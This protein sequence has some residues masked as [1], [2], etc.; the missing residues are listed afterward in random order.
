MFMRIIGISGALLLAFIILGISI[1][2]IS[3]PNYAFYQ[4][5]QPSNNTAF[6][7]DVDYYFPSPGILP[8]N[9]FWGIKVLRDKIWLAVTFDH[10]KRAR[11]ELLFADKRVV[12]GEQ[13]MQKGKSSL[14]TS[15]TQK[16]EQYLLDTYREVTQEDQAK[17]DT[18][19]LYTTLAKSSLRHRET[20]EYE[21]SIAPEDAQPILSKVLDGPKMVYQE[22]AQKLIQKGK[23]VPQAKEVS[24]QINK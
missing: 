13:L 16:A 12:M 8:D 11:L 17:P 4:P 15:T 19:D 22:C 10:I 21:I 2:R 1:I 24:P 23:V 14:A 20:I 5:L 7:T 3:A 6:I 9:P 18:L